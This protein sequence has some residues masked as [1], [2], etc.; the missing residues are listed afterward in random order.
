MRGE[1][2]AS[3]RRASAARFIL[4]DQRPWT[5]GKEGGE[6]QEMRLEHRGPLCRMVSVENQR[7]LA[8]ALCHQPGNNIRTRQISGSRRCTY[9][10]G[11][12]LPEGTTLTSVCSCPIVT[13]KGV[14]PWAMLSWWCFLGFFFLV[15]GIV[16]LL[17]TFFWTFSNQRHVRWSYGA[18]CGNMH[19]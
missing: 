14:L 9:S 7:P 3:M 4:P 6:G 8:E 1:K 15:V 17:I 11:L 12:N 2:R 18:G 5:R 10:T 16:A 19:H 13:K